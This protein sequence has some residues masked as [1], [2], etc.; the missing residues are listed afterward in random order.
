MRPA[1]S[2]ADPVSLWT[3]LTLFAPVVM[4]PILIASAVL[5]KRGQNRPAMDAVQ[6]LTGDR[7]E[8]VWS[9]RA[10]T[11]DGRTRRYLRRACVEAGGQTYLVRLHL[12]YPDPNPFGER[13]IVDAVGPA[14]C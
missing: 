1:G 4:A 9:T 7:A 14:R 5:E 3:G 10:K 8:L 12:K 11:P 6:A 2:R 13:W